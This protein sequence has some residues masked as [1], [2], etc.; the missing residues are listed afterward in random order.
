MVACIAT[1]LLHLEQWREIGGVENYA[2]A[3][4]KSPRYQWPIMY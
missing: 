3:N 1:P 2:P 4:A